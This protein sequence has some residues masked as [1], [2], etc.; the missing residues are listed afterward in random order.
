MKPKP[1]KAIRVSKLRAG[2]PCLKC[3]AI[4]GNCYRITKSGIRLDLKRDHK[5]RAK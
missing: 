2:R 1:R 5:G 3:G 4:M